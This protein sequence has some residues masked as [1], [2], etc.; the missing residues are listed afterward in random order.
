MT[1]Y[2][3]EVTG[4]MLALG[5]LVFIA[6]AT[7]YGFFAGAAA[8]IGAMALYL[9]GARIAVDAYSVLGRW[10]HRGQTGRPEPAD[11]MMTVLWPV[12]LPVT[13]LAYGAM[14]IV[15]R[16]LPDAPR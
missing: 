1:R 14:G 7:A 5:V 15:N 13:L 9:L 4:V 3:Y 10:A 2:K 16:V 6:G 8:A 11:G 12:A